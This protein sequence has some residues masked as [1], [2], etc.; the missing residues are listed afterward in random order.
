MWLSCN[1]LFVASQVVIMAQTGGFDGDDK[2][3]DDGGSKDKS[4]D[5]A[6]TTKAPT[7]TPV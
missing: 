3:D 1:C 7:P 6:A 4:T 5:K 2:D